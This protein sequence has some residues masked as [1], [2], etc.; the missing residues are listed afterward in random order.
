M[1]KSILIIILLL[2][3]INDSFATPNDTEIIYEVMCDIGIKYIISTDNKLP[4]K[5]RSK[6]E[7]SLS[8]FVDFNELNSGMRKRV[9]ASASKGKNA[10]TDSNTLTMLEEKAVL[11]LVP[12]EL[13][14]Y[15]RLYL[16]AMD[17]VT[18]LPTCSKN[19]KPKGNDKFV[20]CEQKVNDSEIIVK[21]VIPSEE[22]V[23]LVFK[24]SDRWRLSNIEK[25]ISEKMLLT[26][27]YWK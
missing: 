11:F 6:W 18:K 2:L 9:R 4:K 13:S 14:D 3:P 8:G 22:N 23:A 1:F 24:K 10:I 15:T 21:I 19:L 16:R 26:I 7:K 20:L 25:V 17:N 27:G 12:R 5:N